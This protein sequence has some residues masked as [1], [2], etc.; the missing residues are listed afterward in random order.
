MLG[1]GIKGSTIAN[2][3]LFASATSRI[4]PARI[5]RPIYRHR[6]QFFGKLQTRFEPRN[7]LTRARAGNGLYGL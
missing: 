2:D 1:S 6:D 5:D 7:L 4:A 3:Q